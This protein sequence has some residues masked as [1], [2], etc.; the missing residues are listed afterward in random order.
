MIAY[1]GC[2]KGTGHHMWGQGWR[3]IRDVELTRNNFPLPRYLDGTS[4]FLPKK[5]IEDTGVLTFLPGPDITILAWWNR[6]FDSRGGTNSAVIKSGNN[7]F[8]DLWNH[9]KKEFPDPDD[10]IKIPKVIKGLPAL[11]NQK[12]QK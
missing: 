2:W 6:I 1:F 11:I 5:E 10:Y 8:N 3:Q 9:F 4:M 7:N 12:E